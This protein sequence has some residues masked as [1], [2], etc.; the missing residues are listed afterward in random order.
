MLSS[1]LSG[2]GHK[3]NVISLEKN[4]DND[5]KAL[6]NDLKSTDF[7]SVQFAPYALSSNGICGYK[8]SKLAKALCPERVHINFHEIWTGAYPTASIKEKFIG[9]RQ[10]KEIL[11][12]LD[13]AKPK[14]VTCSNAAALDRFSQLG[15]KAKYLYLFGNVPYFPSPNLMFSQNLRVALFGT[16][17][18]KFPYSLMCEKLS[19][20]SASLKKPV[21]LRIIGRQR[22]NNGLNYIRNISKKFNFLISETG[23]LS[24]KSIS[25]ELQVC[26]LGVSTTPYDI[27]GKSGASAAMLEHRLPIIAFDDGDT[28]DEQLFVFEQFSG[29]VFLLDD[30]KLVVRLLTFMKKKRKSFFDGVSYT[31]KEMLEFID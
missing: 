16:P 23:E 14:W 7:T 2:F 4:W 11:K 24:P 17:Y 25:M 19:Q 9:W 6:K 21:E 10:K 15:I 5:I 22:E 29:Q 3:C 8:L 12:F 27:L 26:Q 13:L 31:A 18:E 1:Q 20:I 30:D 28:P